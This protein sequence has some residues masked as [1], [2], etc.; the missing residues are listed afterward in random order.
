MCFSVKISA[1]P[2]NL[3]FCIIHPLNLVVFI[4]KMFCWLIRKITRKVLLSLNIMLKKMKVFS[5]LDETF[6]NIFGKKREESCRFFCPFVFW[7]SDLCYKRK[8]QEQLTLFFSLLVLSK[9][10]K[11]IKRLVLVV[12]AYWK[13]ELKKRKNKIFF[14]E[15]KKS[16]SKPRM[17]N[18]FFFQE[19]PA[20]KEQDY[21]FFWIAHL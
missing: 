11:S 14:W 12:Q 4:W 15:Q 3:F 1:P 17:E 5:L 6:Q 21:V 9:K 18:W 19:K 10:K 20:K 7:F 2:V 13:W 16:L 8:K